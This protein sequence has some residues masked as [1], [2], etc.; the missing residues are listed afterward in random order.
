M[1]AMLES[2]SNADDLNICDRCHSCDKNPSSA[3][4]GWIHGGFVRIIFGELQEDLTDYSYV[5]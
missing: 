2:T 4:D 1:E 5:L 3:S